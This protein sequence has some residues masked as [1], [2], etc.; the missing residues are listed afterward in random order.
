MYQAL[1]LLSGECLGTGLTHY[2]KVFLH[3]DRYK[4]SKDIA[5]EKS[6]EL[7]AAHKELAEAKEQY[8]QC[9][10]ELVETH[11]KCMCKSPYSPYDLE[12]LTK[13]EHLSELFQSAF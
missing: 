10:R 1:P 3:T 12:Y 7:Q 13:E 2:I 8:E 4:E 11:Q 6:L 5:E 9:R